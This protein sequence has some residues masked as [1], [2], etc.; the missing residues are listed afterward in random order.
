MR[1][2]EVE[3]FVKRQVEGRDGVLLK[4][5]SPSVAGVPDRIAIMPGGRVLFVEIKR[6][7]GTLSK[8]QAH[9]IDRLVDLGAEV[10]VIYGMPGATEWVRDLDSFV[11]MTGEWRGGD[12]AHAVYTP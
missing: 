4:F 10:S 1:E 3:A 8:I 7:D 6:Q 11:V 12:E 5:V 2:S 9:V